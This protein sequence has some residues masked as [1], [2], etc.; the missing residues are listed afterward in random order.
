MDS[1]TRYIKS[2]PVKMEAVTFGRRS[3]DDSKLAQFVN[4]RN[5]C[6]D[7]IL[8]RT[9]QLGINDGEQFVGQTF[10]D[11]SYLVLCRNLGAHKA[12]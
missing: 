5:A 8:H 4:L 11:V 1:Q 6:N 7:E 12:T 3:Y 9:G 10:A 2:S